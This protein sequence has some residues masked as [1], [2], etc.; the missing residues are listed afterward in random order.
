MNQKILTLFLSF[1]LMNC[2]M[3]HYSNGQALAINDYYPENGEIREFEFTISN[4]TYDDLNQY[5]GYTIGLSYDAYF[6]TNV[7]VIIDSSSE[8][9]VLA[10][11][12][13]Y[14]RIS[15]E[16]MQK[17][18][19]G[20]T[21]TNIFTKLSLHR[22]SGLGI[23]VNVDRITDNSTVTGT[24]IFHT[25]HQGFNWYLLN[26]ILPIVGTITV[27]LT[28]SVIILVIIYFRNKRRIVQ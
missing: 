23:N 19:P 7:T 6:K 24:I 2:I 10:T 27:T 12:T 1:I 11:F 13:I 5:W 8:S 17:L 26:V 20:E 3:I 4:Y 9:S 16:N 25:I 22:N 14:N 21:Y 15:R 18:N 28:I